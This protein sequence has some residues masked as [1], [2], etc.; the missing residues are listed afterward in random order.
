VLTKGQNG[1][2]RTIDV[3]IRLGPAIGTLYPFYGQERY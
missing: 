3:S 1:R 2:G